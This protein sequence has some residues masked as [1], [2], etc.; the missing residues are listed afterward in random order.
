MFTQIFGLP[1][2]ILVVHAVVVLLPLAAVGAV[3][4][5]VAPR[6][7]RT[8]GLPIGVLMLLAV[9]AVPVATRSWPVI[10]ER[11]AQRVG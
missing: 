8:Y 4:L 10:S 1:T 2:H 11:G 3:V 6:L 9:A 5:A 7:I